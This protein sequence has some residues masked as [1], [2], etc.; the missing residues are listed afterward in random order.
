MSLGTPGSI[1]LLVKGDVVI[2]SDHDLVGARVPFHPET[3]VLNLFVATIG[4]EVTSVK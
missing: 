2:A 1:V 4:R 3:K